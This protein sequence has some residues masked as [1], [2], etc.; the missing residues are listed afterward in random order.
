M[1]ER[2]CAMIADDDNGA[3]RAQAEEDE[4][5]LGTEWHALLSADARER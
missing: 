2:W 3:N 5:D 4:E 1:N